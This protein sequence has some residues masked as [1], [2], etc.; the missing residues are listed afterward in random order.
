MSWRHP[1]RVVRSS[2]EGLCARVEDGV[3]AYGCCSF[4]TRSALGPTL[5]SGVRDI[6]PGPRMQH[7]ASAELGRFS[8]DLDVPSHRLVLMY[9]IEEG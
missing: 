1:R 7:Q 3:D 4:I 2:V 5:D 8:G 6:W 9:P